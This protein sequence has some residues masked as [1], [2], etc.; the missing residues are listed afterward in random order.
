LG[1]RVGVS[2][3]VAK[4]PVGAPGPPCRWRYSYQIGRVEVLFPPGYRGS[5]PRPSAVRVTELGGVARAAEGKRSANGTGPPRGPLEDWSGPVVRLTVRVSRPGGSHPSH[6]QDNA[7][8]TRW[9]A[10]VALGGAC[11]RHLSESNR[12]G[13]RGASPVGQVPRRE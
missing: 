9:T 1:G 8:R 12:R 11:A 13:F 5:G 4:S 2:G 6:C 3:L 7:E 10:R